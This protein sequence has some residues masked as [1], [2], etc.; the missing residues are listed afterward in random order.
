MKILSLVVFCVLAGCAGRPSLEELE[1]QAVASG[2]WSGVEQREES[3]QR[4]NKK[5]GPECPEETTSVCLE[6]GMSVSCECVRQNP[7]VPMA[8]D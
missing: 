6:Q 8:T 1:N 5:I 2:D 7:S 3:L 4:Q